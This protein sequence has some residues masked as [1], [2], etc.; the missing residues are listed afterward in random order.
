MGCYYVYR[1]CMIRRPGRVFAGRGITLKG[2]LITVV[3]IAVAFAL[4]IGAGWGTGL[5]ADSLAAPEPT[6]SASPSP[7]PSPTP[8][9]DVSLP[10]M[11]PI[12]RALDADDQAAGLTALTFP[13]RG[14][15]TFRTADAGPLPTTSPGVMRLVKIDAE[16]GLPV[17][18]EG[19]A[20]FVIDTLN[21]PRGWSNGSGVTFV[22]TD[23]AP[24]MRVVLASPYTAAALCPTPHQEAPLTPVSPEPSPSASPDASP[25]ASP[26]PVITTQCASAGVVVMSIYDWAAGIPTFGEDRPASREWL[27]NHGVGHVLGKP[28]ETCRRGVANV[29]A[30]QRELADRCT[31]NP[32]PLPDAS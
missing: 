17:N 13:E 5:V 30:D 28:E 23:G 22:L 8:T 32:W 21:D 12:T 24:D 27:V 18:V 2:T 31:P 16:D 14:K 25:E 6:P 29:M 11:E 7:T 9:I 4:G 26:S 1:R 19:L 15:G 10:P 20:S 3:V